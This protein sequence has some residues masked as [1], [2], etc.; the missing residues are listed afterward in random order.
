MDGVIN[1]LR[2]RYLRIKHE[3]AQ[4]YNYKKSHKDMSNEIAW[5]DIESHEYYRNYTKISCNYVKLC[6]KN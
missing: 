1:M 5:K 2:Y 6:S 4:Y 3:Y